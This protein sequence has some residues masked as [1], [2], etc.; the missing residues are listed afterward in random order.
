MLL[1]VALFQLFKIARLKGGEFGIEQLFQ[2]RQKLDA[3][4]YQNAELNAEIFG[5]QVRHPELT[6]QIVKL[7]H[8][9]GN[10]LVINLIGSI[11]DGGLYLSY[12]GA[13]HICVTVIFTH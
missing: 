13:I 7:Q 9:I 4:I 2:L 3:L 6:E 1:L 5:V 12:T 10:A 8:A 11:F